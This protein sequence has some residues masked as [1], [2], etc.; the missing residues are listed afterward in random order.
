[1]KKHVL[2]FLFTILFASLGF[3]QIYVDE[4]DNGDPANMDGGAPSYTFTEENSQLTV[5]ASNTG[6][7]D[8]FIYKPHDQATG[9]TM[10]LDIT[11]T[12]K[13][14]VRVKASNIGTQ[15]RMDVQDADGFVTSIAGLTKTMTNEFNVLE[16][17]FTG[18]YQDGGFG[19][20]PCTSD[21]A[22]CTVDGTRIAQLVFFTDPGAGGFNGSVVFDYISFGT[23]VAAEAMSDVYQDHFDKG[24][25]TIT[26]FGAVGGGYSLS[27]TDSEVI[28]S[29]DGTT[30]MW[31]PLGLLIRN[32]NTFEPIDI[33]VSGNNKMFVKVKSTIPGTALR[34]DV[35]DID[36][37]VN[38]AGSVTKI[39]GTE[40]EVF[41]YDFT[42]TYQ[43]LGFGGTP[44][45]EST[46]PCVVDAS[47]IANLVMFIEPGVGGF[48]GD[49]TIDY[50]SFGNSLEPPGDEP[51]LIYGDHFS[52]EELE[53]TSSDAF[54]VS[55][56]ESN[57]VITGDGTANP[58]ATVSYI[59]HDKETQEELT[60]DLGPA[61]NKVIINA[62][63]N[64]AMVPL[65]I[66]VVD[67]DNFHSSQSS[68]TKIISGE[69]T[70]FEYDFSGAQDGGFGGTACETG[71]CA[72]NTAAIRQLLIYP[73]PI[74]GE[75]EG[76]ITIDF[77]SIGQ[78]LG[79]EEV[80]LGPKGIANYSDQFDENSALFLSDVTGLSVTTGEEALSITGDGT[81]QPWTPVVYGLHD[82]EGNLI[83]ANATAGA[84]KLFVRARSSVEGT[85]LRVDLQDNMDFV[86][87]A[88][89]VSTTLTSE[90]VVYE[91]D[92]SN[93][94]N[95]GGFGGSPCTADTA[96]CPVD[97]ARIANLQFFLEPG[98]GMFN[99]TVDIDWVSFGT[100]LEEVEEVPAGIVNYNDELPE[101]AASQIT[102]VPGLVTSFV[103]D[104]WTV[105]GDGTGGMWTP[106]VYAVHNEAG[107]GILANAA[108]SG[109]KVYVRARATV[110]GTILRMDL[111]DNMN[112]VTNANAQASTLTEEYVVYEYNYANAYNDG[113][114]GGT[115]CT[116]D[117]APCPVDGE[118]IAQLQFFVDPGVGGFDGILEI[119]WISFGEPLSTSIVD[120]EKLSAIKAY[121]NPT[122][123]QVTLEYDLLSISEVQ[124]KVFDIFGKQ[125]NNQHLGLQTTGKQ[126]QVI[127]IDNYANG[128]YLLQLESKGNILG[129]LRLM[130]N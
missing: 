24:D 40:Y 22:P 37:F 117:T 110:A 121:P 123:G 32:Q 33:D 61:K 80:D 119:D 48:I 125:L 69:A 103:G 47:R 87:N 105:T 7:W 85:T 9:E 83:M 84:N 90:Y 60:L 71:P 126:Q 39:V 27:V 111:Q 95:D 113:G 78:P 6:P 64:G 128:V 92:Y 26:S 93:A 127:H 42:G 30:T 50:I 109:D 28:I 18:T 116:A 41:E 49:L 70:I 67:A 29:G 21:T 10:L 59:L 77:L 45:T 35:Q 101:S 5:N 62:R 114:F 56:S 36:N 44:C 25:S 81:S 120:V 122:N 74:A 99:G 16:F 43:D 72:V 38:T 57:L 31:D 100:S 63:T 2:L 14:F 13:V 88:N 76:E 65:R 17:D 107:E 104:T 108:G 97:G 94:L 130:K 11:E 118:R 52:N 55:E 4:F 124:I 1:M 91:L 15:L 51:V 8:V 75:F 58:F 34:I 46:A 53:F 3:T 12:N 106:L 79:E 102:D 23:E 86:T 20:T 73:D 129:A 19:G 82:E 96:P 112:F 54:D 98:T 115:P 89:A 66:D 68:V